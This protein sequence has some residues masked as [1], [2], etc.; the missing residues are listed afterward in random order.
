MPAARRMSTVPVIPGPRTRR[1][2]LV[3][4]AIWVPAGPTPPGGPLP[5][6]RMT[7][8]HQIPAG[9]DQRVPVRQ[10]AGR[11][12]CGRTG[13]RRV[14]RPNLA[15]GR[16]VFDVCGQRPAGAGRLRPGG[17][18]RHAGAGSP[19]VHRGRRP[20]AA[21]S[22]STSVPRGASCRRSSTRSGS[23]TGPIVSWLNTVHGR[24][25]EGQHAPHQPRPSGHTVGGQTVTTRWV[26]GTRL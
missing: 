23:P 20:R 24:N 9:S 1:G 18:G 8:L 6:P 4:T 15:P 19:G 7:P 11:N 17:R 25:R 3:A 26:L 14:P 13:R 21:L 12:V 5:A 22:P 10:S 16:R 2:R